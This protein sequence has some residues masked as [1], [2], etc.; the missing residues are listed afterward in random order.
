MLK[1]FFGSFSGVLIALFT[2]SIMFTIAAVAAE[3]GVIVPPSQEEMA[4]LM[5]SLLGLKGAGALVIAA[6]VTQA[7]MLALR[8]KLGEVAGKWRLLIVYALSIVTGVL[9][10]RIAGV[11][12]SAALTHANTLAA[13]QVFINQAFK[14][15]FQKDE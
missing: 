14:Q 10:L 12:L 1:N 6:V 8:S 7:V 5:A 15:F 11:D 3:T 4:A 13:F 2:L 9:A